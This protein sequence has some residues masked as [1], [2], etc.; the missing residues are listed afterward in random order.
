ML[1]TL[2]PM[3]IFAADAEKTDFSDM[4]ATDYYAQAAT[5]LEQLDILSGYPDGTFGAE[6]PITRAEMAAIV[7]RMIDKETDAK[8]AMGETI[9]DDVSSDHWASGYINIASKEGIINGD[10]NGKFR[11]EDDV[12][13]EEAIKMVVC[14][15]GYGNDVEVDEKDWSKGYLE[16]ASEKGISDDLKGAKG[17]A[18][19]RG[20]VAVMT[21]NGLATDAE[22]SKIPA[23]PVASVKAGEYKGT[24]K[25]KLTTTTKDADIYYT[26][27]GTT[28]TV[29]STKYTKEIS[30]SKTSTLK[31]IA[32][33]NGV[34]SMG[35][36][37]ADYTIKQVS[38]GGG[39]SRPTT[40]S[41]SFATVENGSVDSSV[42]GSYTKNSTINLTA[43]PDENYV[44]VKWESNNGGTFADANSAT[45]TF[46]MPAKSVVIT[47]VFAEKETVPAEIAE[48]FGIDPDDYDTDNDG[49]SNY[50]EIYITHT[51]P[52]V[53]DT[54]NNGTLDADEDADTDGLTNISEIEAGTDLTK[55]DTDDD[56]LSDFDEVN[57]YNS[58][59][60]EYDTDGDTLSD[61]DE[62]LLGLN[63]LVQKS[64]GTTL[65]SER[66]FTQELSENNIS[67]DLLSEDNAAIPSL[68]LTA[69]G[70]INNDVVISATSSND[71][72]DSR[73]IVG[74]AIDVYGENIYEGTIS[75]AL[76]NDDVSLLSVDD[77]D[78]TF[79][80]NLIC[81][82]NADGSTEYLDTD[83]DS[84]T[85][86]L[87]A[88]INGEG[89]YFVMD[90]KNLFDE[91][92]LAM[93]T[94][95]DLS[96]LTDPKPIALMSIDEFAEEDNQN[97][98]NNSNES[99]EGI[100]LMSIDEVEED[101]NI[102]AASAETEKVTLMASSGAMAQAD[103]VF[104]I[105]TT[106]SMSGAINNVK[107]NVKLFV[108]ELKSRGVSAGLAL[109]EYRDIYEDGYD[110]TK[111]H[112]NGSSNWFYDMDVYKEKVS[113]LRASGG[114][115][116]PESAVD[117]L[118]T[119]RLLDM[120]ASAGKI[121]ILVTDADYKVGNRYDI[122]SMAAEIELLKNAGVSCS[123]VTDSYYKSLYY[124]L[125]N[126]TNGIWAD[127]Y[128]NFNTELTTLADKIGEEIVGDGYWVYLNGPV[129]IPTKL[130]EMPSEDGTADSDDDGLLDKYEL[131]STTPTKTID[132]DELI[133]LISKGVI[134]GTDYGVVKMYEF[135]SNPAE[136]DTDFDGVED[137]VD[138]MPK[139]NSYTNT[140]KNKEINSNVTYNMDFR[141]FFKDNSE[142]NQELAIT[143]SILSSVVYNGI[144]INES[145][146]E[147][148]LKSFGFSADKTYNYKISEP[149]N[150]LS[151]VVFSTK[152]IKYNEKTKQ[153]I[154]IIVR[155]TNSTIEEWASNFD[156]GTTDEYTGSDDWK[157]KENHKGF[158]IA[159]TRILNE[160]Y[161]KNIISNDSNVE[162]VFWITG[163]SR[164]AA[165]A[166]ILGARLSD[167]GYKTFT[168]TFAAPNTT[169]VSESKAKSYTGIFNI[170]NEDDFVPC[171]PMSDWSFKRYGKTTS[172]MSIQK[173]YEKEWEKLTDIWDYNNDRF[174]MQ[175][176]ID[177]L[178]DIVDD[179]NECYKYTCDCHGDGTHDDEYYYMDHTIYYPN[180][181][182]ITN[183]GM[184][185]DSREKA[186]GKIPENA[187][188]YCEITRHDG[189]GIAGWDFDV[190]QTPAYFMQLLAAKMANKIDNYRFVVELNIATKYEKAKTAI[191]SSALG[192]LA[193]PHY[194]ETYYLLSKHAQ[195]GDFR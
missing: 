28:P 165:I 1:L 10:G 89:T 71:F 94:V 157:I 11:P 25:V 140:M 104:I 190:C 93:P 177:A 134:T 120:R 43:T 53:E 161:S 114:G 129:P 154:P 44:F 194:Q 108:D 192:G 174:G 131:V 109:V 100:S 141:N 90:V 168:Y 121:F 158:D 6:K 68:T 18:S 76:Q 24:Q 118:E 125:Y 144:T 97:Q 45:T 66:T 139:S 39:S 191:A 160:I 80:T 3:N 142:Y 23:I 107:N 77:T 164:G 58:N 183:Y 81:K 148:L 4:K 32:V 173:S 171:L 187:L 143:S 180:Y 36:M 64:D 19:T 137:I 29:K 61:G 78:E 12:K 95:A 156:I 172:G 147:G 59:P 57:T 65:D 123:V 138:T 16:V 83:Y 15:L 186:I 17:K 69:S 87:S 13:H 170:V 145:H 82:Y 155:G 117:A 163:H 176:T 189:W 92:G 5:A 98:N 150:H 41:L 55:A 159:A 128:G 26:T 195:A 73:A 132:L 127:L 149:D 37:S 63:P 185:K 52:T 179:R 8:K 2:A 119:A 48:L 135:K 42:A 133:T 102:V 122:P 84:D 116:G 162:T 21:Y 167:E 51:D 47:A 67:E 31:A 101:T 86:T 70:N 124:N 46:T 40:Y 54:D 188:P 152:T 151:E 60:C 30:I 50:I 169:T 193:H 112:K 74:E 103:I 75:F 14:A 126:D 106:G 20:D 136:K 33:K 99:A 91:L 85:N 72:S 146:A 182:K 38:S 27:D 111:V 153:I 115:D 88:D 105:D 113:N 56:G 130:K 7:C 62:I 79:N 175:N 181:I 166:N 110:T 22:N 9:F 184:S 96:S 49:L 34:V 178:A 35:V